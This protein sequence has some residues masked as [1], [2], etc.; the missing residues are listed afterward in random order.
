M[1][2]FSRAP[3]FIFGGSDSK[4]RASLIGGRHDG[5]SKGSSRGKLGWR[6]FGG[7]K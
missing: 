5:I 2:L 1:G 6:V 4:L 7:V 3:D